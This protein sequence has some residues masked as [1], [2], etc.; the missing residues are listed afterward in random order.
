MHSVSE[1]GKLLIIS[2]HLDD[3]VFSC[4]EMMACKGDAIVAT[5]FSGLPPAALPLTPWDAASGFTG[6]HEAME[7]RR[8][9]DRRAMA[10]LYATPVWLDFLDS[11]YNDPPSEIDLAQAIADQIEAH[12]PDTIMLPAGLFHSDHVITHQAGLLARGHYLDRTWYMYEDMLYRR[13]PRLL[14]ER[15]TGL[16]HFGI[17]ATPVAFNTHDQAER[18]RQAVQCYASQLLALATP[19]RAGHGD[20]YAP[21]GYWRLSADAPAF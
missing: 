14:Q 10:I 12:E 17:D 5:M 8:E 18:K 16:A 1:L 21:E 15:L 20:I 4:G 3:A 7:L 11:Q 19:G 9:E 6:S 2:P 13:I